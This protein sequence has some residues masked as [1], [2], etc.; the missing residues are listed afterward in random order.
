MSD[1]YK[2]DMRESK[3]LRKEEK[4]EYG[5]FECCVRMFV[6]GVAV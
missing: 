4:I 2:A 6:L 5:K 3:R 1:E